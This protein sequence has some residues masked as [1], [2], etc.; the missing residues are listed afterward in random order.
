M[1]PG[2]QLNCTCFADEQYRK[3]MYL[4]FINNAL[5][6]KS[7]VGVCRLYATAGANGEHRES[8]MRLTNW[9][10]NSTLGS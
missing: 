2:L 8:T 3:D 4:A 6:Q 7:K 5:Q 1:A 10:T 9:S